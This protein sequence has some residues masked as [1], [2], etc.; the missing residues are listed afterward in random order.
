MNGDRKMIFR[1]Q[2]KNSNTIFR[3]GMLCLLIGSLVPLLPQPTSDFGQGILQ[4]LR[5]GLFVIT[6]WLV[7]LARSQ[8]CKGAR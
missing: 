6:L 2:L 5:I 4:G 1:N 3:I 8:R 7:K